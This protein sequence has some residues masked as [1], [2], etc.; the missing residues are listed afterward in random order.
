MTAIYAISTIG[1]FLFA[2]AA[3]FISDAAASARGQRLWLRAMQ[4][5]Y[6]AL[7][8]LLAIK[9][10]PLGWPYFEKILSSSN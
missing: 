4:I 10:I 5:S 7:L 2:L 8:I 1:F 9:I 6:L 3:K